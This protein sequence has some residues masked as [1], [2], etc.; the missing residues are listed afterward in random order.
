MTVFNAMGNPWIT[1]EVLMFDSFTDP[2]AD[3]FT[4]VFAACVLVSNLTLLS[5]WAGGYPMCYKMV[6]I[7]K[8]FNGRS[9]LNK[10]SGI[11]SDV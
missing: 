1:K 7:I 11:L 9:C 5:R 6:S 3:K 10:L 2:G 8:M 4:T